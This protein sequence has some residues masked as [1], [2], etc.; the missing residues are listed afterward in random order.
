MN[1]QSS[2]I[3]LADLPRGSKCLIAAVEMDGLLKRRILDLG[4]V[5]GTSVYCV[6]TGPSGDP[7]AYLVR[8]SV[9]ALRRQDANNIKVYPLTE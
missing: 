1:V 6:R 7:I 3:T 2:T 8:G 9:I 4:M 5:P